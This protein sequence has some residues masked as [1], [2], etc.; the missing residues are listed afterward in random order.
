MN[1]LYWLS[2]L[3]VPIFFWL[4]YGPG[5]ILLMQPGM[6]LS[7][8]FADLTLGQFLFVAAALWCSSTSLA[9]TINLVLLYGPRRIG[10]TDQPAPS[11][12]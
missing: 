12:G 10:H 9:A 11:S 7:R 4:V 1:F 2:L 8:G 5:L 6:S 3:R